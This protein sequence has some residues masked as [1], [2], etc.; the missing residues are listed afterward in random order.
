MKKKGYDVTAI[1]FSN[2]HDKREL[3]KAKK[4]ASQ[5]GI[6][7][8][9][10]VNHKISQEAFVR[11]CIRRFQCLLCKRVMYRVAEKIAEKHKIKSLLT[12]ESLGQVGS[13]TLQNLIVLDKSVTIP[14]H[15]PLL[16]H[17]KNE[18]IEIARKIGTYEISTQKSASCPYVPHN[19]L[20][21]AKLDKVKEQEERIDMEQLIDDAVNSL[22]VLEM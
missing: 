2:S 9:F 18:T 17:D 22:Q 8:M 16:G 21:K 5:I 1:H 20:T 3:E 11:N 14:V 10:I 4:L 12:G 6:T 19:P 13:Q 7:K 15:R